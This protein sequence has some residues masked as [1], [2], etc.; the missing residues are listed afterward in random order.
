[1]KI[2]HIPDSADGRKILGLATG[3]RETIAL[4][5]VQPSHNPLI[6]FDPGL[7]QFLHQNSLIRGNSLVSDKA[8]PIVT[9]QSTQST[10]GL[11]VVGD[12]DTRPGVVV[13]TPPGTLGGEAT[14]SRVQGQPGLYKAFQSRGKKRL[15]QSDALQSA[16][17]ALD[18]ES[19]W[20][21]SPYIYCAVTNPPDKYSVTGGGVTT[22]SLKARK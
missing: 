16:T 13:Y 19:L 12:G 9:T 8:G 6:M 11:A 22:H 5:S 17:M 14:G 20:E 3:P 7:S 4:A 15:R 18:G 10:A 2:L 1:M 21:S